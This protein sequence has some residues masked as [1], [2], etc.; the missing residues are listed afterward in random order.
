MNYKNEFEKFMESHKTN[1]DRDFTNLSFKGGKYYIQQTEY[2]EFLDLYEKYD[3][4]SYGIV[5]KMNYK[6]DYMRFDLDF[7]F[8]DIT[9]IK[10]KDITNICNIIKMKINEFCDIKY[11]MYILIRNKAVFKDGLYKYG[12]HIQIPDIIPEKKTLMRLIRIELIKDNT[13]IKLFQDMKIINKIDDII[14]ESVYISNGWMLYGSDKSCDNSNSYNLKYIF[15]NDSKMIKYNPENNKIN[16]IKLFSIRNKIVNNMIPLEINEIQIEKINQIENNDK[17]IELNKLRIEKE[18]KEKKNNIKWNNV[19]D[20]DFIKELVYI[21]NSKRAINYK[22]WSELGWCLKSIDENTFKLFDAFSKLCEDKYNE[23]NVEKFWNDSTQKNYTMGTLRYWAKQDNPEKYDEI[24]QKYKKYDTNI[25]PKWNDDS[26]AKDFTN[27]YSDKF[28]FQDEVMYY[29]NGVYWQIDEKNRKLKNFIANEYFTDLNKINIS[30]WNNELEKPD[31]NKDDI[32][33]RF[34]KIIKLIGSLKKNTFRKNLAECIESYLINDDIEFDTKP[35]LFCFKNKVW[36]LSKGEFIK[37]NPLDYLSITSGYNYEEDKDLHE[38]MKVIDKFLKEILPNDEVRECTLKIIAS[39]M[40]GRQLDKFTIFNGGG[41]NGKG[42]LDK[43][44]LLT[45]GNYGCKLDNSVLTEK[46]NKSGGVNPAKA[47][48][49]KKRYVISTEPDTEIGER[50]NC[51]TIKEITGEK[52]LDGARALYS[53]NDSISL[54]L[55]LVVECNEK[56]KMNEANNAMIRRIMDIL[57]ESQFTEHKEDIDEENGIYLMN[58]TLDTDEWREQYK[59]AMFHYLQPYFIKLY[60]DGF[61]LNT[62]QIIK[63]RNEKYLADSNDIFSW[64]KSKMDE[65][66][67]GDEYIQKSDDKNDIIKIAD[68]FKIFK[69]STYFTN[70]N[71]KEKREMNKSKFIEKIIQIKQFK[72]LYKDRYKIQNNN[73]TVRNILTNLKIIPKNYVCDNDKL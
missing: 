62:P 43:L 6:Y 46:K 65:D 42:V 68:L 53:S 10:K 33:E 34:L 61:N 24:C 18:N 47:K 32:D 67:D 11:D 28:I 70:L 30:N 38:N 41:G 22:T 52:T 44:T 15:D 60:N 36:D 51:S 54:H 73:T 13:L 57:F 71:K 5:E 37:P 45:F 4:S 7:K 21:L 14:D 26:I 49:D 29:F 3:G 50:F 27:R 66:C 23:D 1:K 59:I 9:K 12:I 25:L 72:I 39:G 58:K 56:P 17:E 20:K 19:I 48:L 35:Y 55:T 16:L 8:K 63:N 31:A 2:E 69:D 64:F 40:C